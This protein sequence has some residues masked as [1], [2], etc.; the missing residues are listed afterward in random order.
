[1]LTGTQSSLHDDKPHPTETMKAAQWTGSRSVKIG[2]VPKPTITAPKDTIVR[3]THCC[4]C[5]SDLHMYSGEMN[6]VM[7]Q[8]DILG[9]EAIGF[10][11][12]VG[13]MVQNF[14]AGD[15]VIILPVIACGECF[16][17]K[18]QQYSLCDKTNPSK[19]MEE[20]YA[21]V[22]PESSVTPTSLAA[23][24]VTR[25]SSAVFQTLSSCW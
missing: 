9:H 20:M 17:C 18:E 21:T 7:Q 4:I 1:M 13:P 23:T 15:R 16:Y 8:G 2:E 22:C 24:Q 12:D 14:K 11:E 10:V 6:M 5:G 3:I 19:Q 25:P